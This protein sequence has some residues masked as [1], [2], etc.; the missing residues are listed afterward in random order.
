MALGSG[1][2]FVATARVIAIVLLGV[3]VGFFVASFAF[4]Q[5]LA[6]QRAAAVA[7]RQG[8]TASI[9]EQIAVDFSG[10]AVSK[11]SF[12]SALEQ[13]LSAQPV[14]TVSVQIRPDYDIGA[15]D[16]ALSDESY[17]S[18]LDDAARK[19]KL[20][21]AHGGAAL[22]GIASID[23]GYGG[24][25]PYPR[26]PVLRG[27]ANAAAPRA[28]LGSGPLVLGVSYRIAHGDPQQTISVLGYSSYSKLASGRARTSTRISVMV[29][30]RGSDLAHAS[31]SA[32][33]YEG[34]VRKVAAQ[35]GLP[36]SAVSK[37][38]VSLNVY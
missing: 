19:A 10:T 17:V 11:S 23:E 18:A 26:S 33:P 30:A 12:T 34:Y 3:I 21:A 15:P 16:L 2:S 20:L 35:L 28:A 4:R 24:Q 31:Q 6:E 25:P 29:D 27:P 32:A 8:T 7:V 13:Q 5:A 9:Q 22:G 1:F 37:A 36:P 14:T 38:D